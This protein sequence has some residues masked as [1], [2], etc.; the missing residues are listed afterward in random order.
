[1][2]LLDSIFGTENADKANAQ[3]ANLVFN[4]LSAG[5]NLHNKGTSGKIMKELAIMNY[6]KGVSNQRRKVIHARGA[7]NK[8]AESAAR[9]GA[10]FA[11]PTGGQSRTA[12]R[13]QNLKLLSQISKAENFLRY[14]KG[15]QTAM[16]EN[17]ALNK[18]QSDDA[19]GNEMIGVAV[20]GKRGITYTKDNN[21]LK[22]AKLAISVGTGNLGGLI[23]DTATGDQ[24]VF[25]FLGNKM[26][27][28]G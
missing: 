23:P 27:N 24:S 16:A 15:E 11:G 19:R 9:V 14:S 8:T 28:V 13:N 1:M 10:S 17:M 25:Q 2:G 6:R 22:F 3:Q 18:L 26:G 21:A 12:G 7:A 5:N 20:P 4:S